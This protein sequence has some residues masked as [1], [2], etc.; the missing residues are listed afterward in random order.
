M[1]NKLT[2]T[3]ICLNEEKRIRQCLESVKWADEIVLVD[4]G[5]TDSTLEIAK[6]YTDRIFVNSDWQGFGPQKKLAV[7][8]ASN[9][10]VLA[11]D[12]DEVVSEKLREEIIAAIKDVDE[13][14][15]FRLNRLTSFC[16][17]FIKHSGWHPDRIVRLFNKN[18][19][20]YNEA[21]VHE[22]VEC[23]GASKIDLK[24]K[25]LHYQMDSLE[26][27]INKRNRYA[28]AWAESQ[29]KK[30]KRTNFLEIMLHTI[31]SFLR[32]YVFRL[33]VLDGYHGFMIAVIQMQYTFNKYN[34]LMFKFKNKINN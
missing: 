11:L 31:F 26:E 34:F 25:L 9:D 17:K 10:W 16:G 28:K 8:Y 13:Y 33:G 29:Y 6:E 27:Y 21:F 7:N 3:I 20:N 2:V 23:A 22:A 24:Q 14:T 4:S 30:G 12:S 5:S 32:H 19:Y 15:V 1:S 18:H